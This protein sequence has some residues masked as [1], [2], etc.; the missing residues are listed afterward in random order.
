MSFFIHKIVDENT[1]QEIELIFTKEVNLATISFI[2]N[3]KQY[4]GRLNLDS[5]DITMD[6]WFISFQN[7]VQLS[8]KYITFQKINNVE[9]CYQ[10]NIEIP[11]IGIDCHCILSHEEIIYDDS[12]EIKKKL[13]HSEHI[14]KLL[15][16]DSNQRYAGITRD[17][18]QFSNIRCLDWDMSLPTLVYEATQ[19][20]KKNIYNYGTESSIIKRI[21]QRHPYL[22]NM[23]MDNIL[24]AG[25][26]ISNAILNNDKITDIDI[27]IYGLSAIEATAKV[28]EI[29]QYISDLEEEKFVERCYFRK[30]T[31]NLTITFNCQDINHKVQIMFRL[32]NT[33]S[34][35]LH[36]FDFGSAAVGF[37]GTHIITTS[38]G[39]FSYKFR[40]NILDTSRRSTTYEKRLIKYLKRGFEIVLPR[41]D[42]QTMEK[43]LPFSYSEYQNL[44]LPYLL[45]KIKKDDVLKNKIV[46]KKIQSSNNSKSDYCLVGE[47]IICKPKFKDIL[48]YCSNEDIINI[49]RDQN[50]SEDIIRLVKEKNEE[51]KITWIIDNPGKQFT[52]SFNPIIK[53]E[54][55]WYGDYY[56][57]I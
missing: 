31:R 43:K 21:H 54:F 10:L 32:Y 49:L 1:D 23:N 48:Q 27:F 33:K 41:F 13:P 45:I 35:I 34:E 25:G 15:I 42:I 50:V 5:F 12:L 2:L 47:T 22:K 29:G 7:L 11:F 51:R 4:L 40:I 39:L 52:T 6:D 3:E 38:L 17:L 18:H 16:F 8:D 53:D 28:F 55:E 30:S 57:T 37:D 46:V 19:I 44:N 20:A 26:S 14:K 36:G 56:Q 24:I 9:D